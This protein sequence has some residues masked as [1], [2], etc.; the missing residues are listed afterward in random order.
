MF[1][2]IIYLNTL[3]LNLKDSLEIAEKTILKCGNDTPNQK[4][5]D[6][7]YNNLP[8]CCKYERTDD[9]EK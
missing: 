5:N 2:H 8:E 4:A 1:F 3:K 9:K 7:A 6:E